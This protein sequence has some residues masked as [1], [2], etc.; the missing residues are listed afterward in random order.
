MIWALV[1]TIKGCFN[2]MMNGP[3]KHNKILYYESW[4]IC[5]VCSPHQCLSL[6][7]LIQNVRRF[8]WCHGTL[9]WQWFSSCR[10]N[11]FSWILCGITFVLPHKWWFILVTHLTNPPWSMFING[12]ASCTIPCICIWLQPSFTSLYN[13]TVCKIRINYYRKAPASSN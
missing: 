5:V 12:F 13:L 6:P 7:P 10:K 4:Y 3:L 9:R 1:N 8:M 2:E 11:F